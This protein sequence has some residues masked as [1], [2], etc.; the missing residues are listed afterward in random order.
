MLLSYNQS[1]RISS[2]LFPSYIVQSEIKMSLVH[3]SLKNVYNGNDSK[4]LVLAQTAESNWCG[5]ETW[6]SMLPLQLGTLF[7]EGSSPTP[8]PSVTTVLNRFFPAWLSQKIGTYFKKNIYEHLRGGWAASLHIRF[9]KKTL[10]LYGLQLPVLPTMS[11]RTL[12]Q[13]PNSPQLLLVRREPDY[14]ILFF[15]FHFIIYYH[16][17][18]LSST[19]YESFVP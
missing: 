19:I 4:L 14:I 3:R 15:Y 9:I 7:P 17:H 5:G 1:K 18:L 2:L 16:H 6:L 13:I 11:L 8:S 10:L 12:P